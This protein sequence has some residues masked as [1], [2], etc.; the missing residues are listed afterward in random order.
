MAVYNVSNIKINI[1]NIFN[2]IE[3]NVTV[4]TP[5]TTLQLIC[6]NSPFYAVKY[7]ENIY[8]L[9]KIP[10]FSWDGMVGFSLTDDDEVLYWELVN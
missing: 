9:T 3:T 2:D 10:N 8:S 7:N 6:F 5:N 4:Q 1:V